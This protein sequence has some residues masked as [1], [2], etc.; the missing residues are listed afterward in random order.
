MNASLMEKSN[1]KQAF[2]PVD[3]NTAAV[4]GNRIKLDKG[5]RV[6]VVLSMG[7]S[8]A[9]VV[10][11]TLRQHNAASA[12][13]SKD[14][15]SDNPYYTKKGAETAFT[16]VVPSSAAALIDVSTQFAGDEGLLVAEILAEQLDINN[17]FYWFSID[18]ADSTAAKLGAAV[19]ILRDCRHQPP[20]G[21]DI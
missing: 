3:L 2:L 9:A 11:V 10:Q 5:D 4:T 1:L 15:T 7:D 19:Y 17:G 16:K 12:G 18:V 8:T 20:Y 14:L 21:Q 13:T 6:A